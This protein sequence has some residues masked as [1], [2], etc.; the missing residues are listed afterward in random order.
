MEMIRKTWVISKCHLRKN[1]SFYK[2][3]ESCEKKGLSCSKQLH[4]VGSVKGRPPPHYLSL[5]VM[6]DIFML[7]ELS[8]AK[9]WGLLLIADGGERLSD[10]TST[11][12]FQQKKTIHKKKDFK[13]INHLWW[14]LNNIY[15]LCQT[16]HLWHNVTLR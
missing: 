13:T 8:A 4:C 3:Q 11:E 1:K 9:C 14:E 15:W 6:V 7:V 5:L 16:S 12:Y 10:Y 2:V